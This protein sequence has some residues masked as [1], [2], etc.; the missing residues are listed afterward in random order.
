MR[1]VIAIVALSVFLA[2][3]SGCSQTDKRETSNEEIVTDSSNPNNM[4][5][6]NTATDS[7]D[8]DSDKKADKKSSKNSLRMVSVGEHDCSNENGYYYM[9]THGDEFELKNGKIAYHIMY[10][11]YATRKEVFLCNNAGCKHN[12]EACTSVFTGEN[13][14]SGILFLHN[15]KL[16]LLDKAPDDE[17]AS[18]YNMSD[19]EDYPGIEF[20]THNNDAKQSLYRMNPDGTDREKVLE[21]EKGITLDSN[22]L[23]DDKGLYF[24]EK[25]IE[26]K[27]QGSKLERSVATKKKLVK[28]NDKTGKKETVC[29][30]K[31]ADKKNTAWS[32]MGCFDSY[33][34]MEAYVMNRKLS[35]EEQ[36][37]TIEDA[38]FD[39]EMAKNSKIEFAV[40]DITTGQF[41]KICSFANKVSNSYTQKDEFLYMIIEGENKVRKID[42]TSGQESILAEIDGVGVCSVFDGKL[43]CVSWDEEKQKTKYYVNPD[44][45]KI[46]KKTID[47]KAK[48]TGWPIEYMAETKNQFLVIY[49]YKAQKAE[50]DPRDTGDDA[51]NVEQNKMALLSKEDYYNNKANYKPIAMVGSG[52][53]EAGVASVVASSSG[54]E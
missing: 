36:I 21:F 33:L 44:N 46:E 30:L 43:E 20:Q 24:I 17:G 54:A 19:S 34:V 42:L 15:G 32:V 39:R 11:D 29:D 10:I 50:R 40:V 2:G 52:G 7:P 25:K 14:E 47:L 5:A 38:D 22:V 6:E 37:R 53:A 16:Y 8:S 27:K 13:F 41:K 9:D 23:E 3:M 48:T 51:Y 35:E 28:L 26:S 1:K 18:L 45:G 31:F 12:S 49:D 4:A